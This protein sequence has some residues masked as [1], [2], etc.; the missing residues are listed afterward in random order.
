MELYT[1]L[2]AL[3]VFVDPPIKII[4]VPFTTHVP[5]LNITRGSLNILTEFMCRYGTRKKIKSKSKRKN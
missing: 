1:S 4:S 5:K 3:A 2:M